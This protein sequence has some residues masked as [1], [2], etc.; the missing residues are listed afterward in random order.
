[1]TMAATDHRPVTEVVLTPMRRRHLRAVMRIE[2]QTQARGWSVGL[3]LGE[4][5]RPEGRRYLVAKVGAQVVGFGGMLFIGSDGHVT[6]LS[7]D[8]AWRRQGIA[9]HL[10]AALCREAIARGLTALTLEVRA[11]N[12]EAQG[13]YRAF[14]FAPAGVRRNYYAETGEDALVMWAHEIDEP[15]YAGRL[16]A[17]DRGAVSRAELRGLDPSFGVNP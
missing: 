6:T 17:L 1:M 9:T 11:H 15:D 16:D 8:P 3:F 12:P 7:V 4:L 2:A 5:A 14:G 13:L 10:L